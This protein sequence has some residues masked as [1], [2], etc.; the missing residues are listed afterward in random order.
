MSKL[1]PEMAEY[2][3]KLA[4]SLEKEVEALKFVQDTDERER[5]N[6]QHRI[7]DRQAYIAATRGKAAELRKII[8]E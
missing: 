6:I 7:D 8:A 3:A 1:T 2:F 4:T 5:D